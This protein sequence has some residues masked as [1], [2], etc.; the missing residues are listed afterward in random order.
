MAV[1]EGT[2]A[3]NPDSVLD[4]P[5]LERLRQILT[6]GHPSPLV[7]PQAREG[8]RA[9]LMLAVALRA[10]ART[11]QGHQLGELEDRLVQAMLTAM[12]HE[13][14][15][16]LGRLY[17]FLVTYGTGLPFP[18]SVT[19]RPLG[20]AYDWAEY[21]EDWQAMARETM[22]QPNTVLVSREGLALGEGVDGPE[23]VDA[24]RTWRA[25]TSAM[26]G[27]VVVSPDTLAVA[28]DGD[29]VVPGV[30]GGQ[31]AEGSAVGVSGFDPVRVCLELE[32][33]HVLRAQ[34]DQGGGKDETY[35][36]ASSGSD[37]AA[38]PAYRSEE[39]QEVKKGDTRTF[40]SN[41]VIFDGQVAGH[42]ILQVFC[43][44]ADQSSSEWYDALHARLRQLSQ[45]I[46]DAPWFQVGANLPG[47][48]IAGILADINTLGVIL[49]SHLRN[50]DDLSCARAIYL[51]R[52]DLALLSERGS[53]DLHFNG[54][55][56]HVLKLKYA[57]PEKVPFP[58]GTLQYLVQEQGNR[59]TT[60]IPLPWQSITPPAIAFYRNRLHVL[61]NRDDRALMW[62]THAD[63]VWSTPR[64]INEEYSDIA[65]ALAVWRDKLWC[66]HTGTDDTVG[67]FT[68]D[69]SSWTRRE[70]IFEFASR[71]APAL[72][73]HDDRLW[74][75]HIG[76]A[77]EPHT[78]CHD[79]N[80][81]NAPKVDNLG[82]K[83]DSPVSMASNS[84][85]LWRVARGMDNGFHASNAS[86]SGNSVSW[87]RVAGISHPNYAHGPALLSHSGGLEVF[88]HNR[89]DLY[90]MHWLPSQNM[91]AGGNFPGGR[92]IHPMDEISCAMQDGR[93][94]VMYRTGPL[95]VTSAPS[96]T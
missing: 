35:W 14:L 24:L 84:G 66:A 9:N 95:A 20:Q 31:V 1:D 58:V 59:W 2:S 92:T 55:G 72:A 86:T 96:T 30:E 94:Y 21:E 46:F 26:P 32:S 79:G 18:V 73:V 80:G 85:K 4:D 74:L 15:I 6:G 88:L 44:E 51:D 34:G 12:S 7:R 38:G 71:V 33:F 81:W 50:E 76:G 11:E 42:L 25:G 91:W 27:A 47:G 65:P 39:F 56:H 64:Q 10:A 87:T 67:Y 48:G 90:Q 89:G 8:T 82:W 40:G 36:C 41:R 52:H 75:T 69:G 23:F 3:G 28:P 43:F 68:F 17:L 93:V 70:R 53:V 29:P 62:T 61:F 16:G 49:M 37:K 78:N 13:H 19:G 22:A 5:R 83:L 77:D 54:D 60:P 63:G 45:S 57:S